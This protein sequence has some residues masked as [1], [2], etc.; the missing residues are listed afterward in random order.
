M[1]VR[2]AVNSPVTVLYR[3]G[4]DLDYY[5][6][7]AGGYRSDADEDRVSVRFANGQ[8]ETRS[9]ALFWSTE[10]RPLPGSTISVPAQDPADRLDVRGLVADI[11]AIVGSV[12]TVIVVLTR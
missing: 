2:G 11:V 10:P 8:A 12:T 3:E 7:N 5:V 4:A 6:A 9:G 1:I